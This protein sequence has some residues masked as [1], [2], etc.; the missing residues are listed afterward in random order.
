[1]LGPLYTTAG[2]GKSSWRGNCKDLWWNCQNVNAYIEKESQ[3]VYLTSSEDYKLNWDLKRPIDK[4]INNEFTYSNI[5]PIEK[6]I[7]TNPMIIDSK[8]QTVN[9]LVKLYP[10]NLDSKVT[11]HFNKMFSEVE[12][13]LGSL[14]VGASEVSD[15]ST[16]NQ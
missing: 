1:M 5:N 3:D 10:L 13:L 6:Y 2:N 4:I 9:Y 15:S 7:S 16:S 12:A 11:Y 8:T 14:V